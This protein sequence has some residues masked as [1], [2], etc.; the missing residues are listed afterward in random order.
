MPQCNM[1]DLNIKTGINNIDEKHQLIFESFNILIQM[2][3]NKDNL[4]N[5]ANSV[6]NIKIY[7][8]EHFIEEENIMRE[9]NA[10]DQNHFKEHV[11]FIKII[12]E[13]LTN[14]HENTFYMEILLK[15]STYLKYHFNT[16]DKK[17]AE[18]ILN[19]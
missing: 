2:I 12:N 18:Q 6:K 10:I 15:I 3:K 4:E 16:F 7:M 13:S 1:F 17:L 5:I 9:I 14:V 19:L 8:Q 11:N